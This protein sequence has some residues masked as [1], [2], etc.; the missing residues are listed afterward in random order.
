MLVE[1][2]FG[3][4]VNLPHERVVFKNNRES[5]KFSNLDGTLFVFTFE[6]VLYSEYFS[7]QKKHFSFRNKFVCKEGWYLIQVDIHTKIVSN[8]WKLNKLDDV[9]PYKT[10]ILLR[11]VLVLTKKII[12]K[13]YLTCEIL[14]WKKLTGFA[15]LSTGKCRGVK[16]FTL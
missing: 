10:S 16:A 7:L 5:L 8:Q 14:C 4:Y 11:K 1:V 12:S 6:S 13:L 2:F 3:H 15:I 9:C